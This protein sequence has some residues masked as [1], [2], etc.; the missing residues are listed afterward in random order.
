MDLLGVSWLP[1]VAA[2]AVREIG[3]YAAIELIVPGGTLIALALW[4][5]RHRASV[6]PRVRR[7]LLAAGLLGASRRRSA[8]RNRQTT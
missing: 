5:Y 1:R 2:K 3:P 7:F 4:A 8:L 6:Q